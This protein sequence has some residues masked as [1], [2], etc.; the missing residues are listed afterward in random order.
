MGETEG[1]VASGPANAMALSVSACV[2]GRGASEEALGFS[3]GFP[4]WWP[5]ASQSRA[6]SHLDWRLAARRLL[7]RRADAARRRVAPWRCPPLSAVFAAG[8]GQW[9]VASLRPSLAQSA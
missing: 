7:A 4:G 6:P 5:V 9:S 8:R 3:Q 2:R 1:A